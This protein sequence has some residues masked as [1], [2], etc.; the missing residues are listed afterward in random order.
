MNPA[1]DIPDIREY[2]LDLEFVLSVISDGP[3]KTFAFRRLQYLSGKFT[4]YSEFEELADMKVQE[5]CCETRISFN[6]ILQRTPQ[7]FVLC[8]RSSFFYT[9]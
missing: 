7:R 3:T 6:L 4:M 9:Q 5:F 1:F 2:F 8:T